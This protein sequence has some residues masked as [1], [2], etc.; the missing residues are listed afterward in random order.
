MLAGRVFGSKYSMRRSRSGFFRPV[1]ARFIAEV[2]VVTMLM[3]GSFGALSRGLNAWP[4]SGYCVMRSK[5]RPASHRKMSTARAATI[6][7]PPPTATMRSAPA[8]RAAPWPPRP[9]GTSSRSRSRRTC[10]R[11]RRPAPAPPARRY[12]FATPWT[13]ELTTKARAA[14]RRPTSERSEVPIA[15]SAQ[16]SRQ[17]KL[18]ASNVKPVSRS[19]RGRRCWGRRPSACAGQPPRAPARSGNPPTLPSNL[20]DDQRG[21]GPAGDR[22]AGRLF[23]VVEVIGLGVCR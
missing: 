6:T 1:P 12:W 16:C 5:G 22:R 23:A 20:T 13:P 3:I 15:P 18:R 21:L 7:L 9:S 19:L 11:G 8:S 14:P 2:G 10:P 4:P 17:A